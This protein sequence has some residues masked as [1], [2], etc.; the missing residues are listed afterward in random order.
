MQRRRLH[1]QCLLA[2]FSPSAVLDT[3][4][5]LPM[6]LPHL[7]CSCA[8]AA[9]VGDGQVLDRIVCCSRLPHCRHPRRPSIYTDALACGGVCATYGCN[10]Y[11]G[12]IR[13]R[14]EFPRR[15]THRAR[16]IYSH[17]QRSLPP[18]DIR[19][20]LIYGIDVMNRSVKDLSAPRSFHSRPGTV[21]RWRRRRWRILNRHP[22]S[23]TL[24]A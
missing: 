17:K 6:R 10:L 7:A 23:C 22:T 15:R 24:A 4:P 2:V 13:P 11:Q 20:P 18:I 12:R 14:Q 8:L 16:D 3:F 21:H 5:F 1:H 19:M 9:N